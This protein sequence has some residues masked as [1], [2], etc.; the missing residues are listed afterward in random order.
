M[1][2]DRFKTINIEYQD[3]KQRINTM[4]K[5]QKTLLMIL[6]GWGIGDGSKGDIIA[7]A[8]T[9][10][11]D[12]M[13]EKYPHSQ[14]LACG[15]DVGL[16][17]GQ[18]GNSEVGHLSIGA[19]RVLYQ[20]MVKITK[21]IRDKSLWKNPQIVKAYNYAKENKKKV[22]LIGLI[23][24]GGVHALSTHMVA[25]CQIATDMG[26]K[27]VFVHGLM[28]GRDT[29]PRSGYGFL[30]TDLKALETT[31]AKFASVIGR[32]F[33]M[34]R[35]KNYDRLKLAYDLYTHGKGDKSTDLLATVKASY[36]AGVT[37]EFMKPIVMVDENEK[38]VGIIEE[39]D[40][41]ICFNF[42]T[43]RLRQTTIAFTQK[44]LPEFGMHTMNLQWYTMTNYK[45]DFKG[46]N[47]IFDKDNVTNTMG[48]VVSNAGL[49]QIRIAET[50]KY[51]HVTF[52]FSGG[53][54][55]EFPGE[56]RILVQ[57]PKV[58][59][60][61]LQPE[62][63]APLVKDAIVPK[64]RNGE[65]DF[66]CLN[67]AN[68]DMVGHTGVYEAIY[69]AITAVDQCAKEVVEAALEGGFNIM[70]IADHGNADNAINEDGSENT[71]HSLNP[72]PCI[73]IS[74][75]KGINL[76]NGILADVAPTLLNVMGLEVPKDM[77]G[78]NL[79]K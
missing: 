39:G 64:L 20:D 2:A 3:K 74:D 40:V 59:T 76:Q 38:P 14:L 58:P 72:V 42:R 60:Y 52:F 13:M 30:E 45:A 21:A 46:I 23:G 19:G 22:H 24:P 75:K 7:T 66:V 9:P 4:A 77:T 36:D 70:I 53:R 29:D 6:D 44:D 56:S 61:D 68:G 67:F 73:F 31:N 16:P 50:E 27:D 5:I 15:E 55:D 41:V 69:K 78:K 43:D 48:E 25:M 37:D 47:V 62:M 32:Y 79:I 49:K 65:A 51:A 8:P 54:E 34:D 17:E 71:A 18:M 63:S 10:F 28:D 35:D 12:S 1:S 11:M 57:S 33:G 26:L